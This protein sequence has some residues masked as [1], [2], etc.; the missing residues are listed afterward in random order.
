MRCVRLV[1][2]IEDLGD[3][4]FTKETG[5]SPAL[6]DLYNTAADVLVALCAHPPADELGLPDGGV[7]T[8]ARFDAR[9]LEI[10]A[11]LL[12]DW[13]Y[14]AVQGRETSADIRAAFQEAFGALFEMF[15]GQDQAWVLR[16][17]H[18]PNLLWLP[19]REG[20]ARVGVI[21][22][23][24]AVRGHAAYDLVSLLQDARRDIPVA[25]EER[26]YDHYCEAREAD[27]AG[28]D[29]DAFSSCYATLGAQRNCKI[30]G[31][32]ARLAK[33]DGKRVYLAHNSRVSEY[34]ERDLAH[35]ALAKLRDWFAAHLPRDL[36][37]KP[38][39]I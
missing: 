37:A 21:D 20:L 26:L 1:E 38:L 16:D 36:R 14:P 28:F 30:L 25:L 6:E 5:E 2:L 3:R 8:L 11:E 39:D 10:E 33:R 15:V 12:L 31:I 34:L 22:F 17:Y 29:R 18:S 35:P 19:A 7:H 32:F 27:D 23:Q 9:A 24:D 4:V 13:F